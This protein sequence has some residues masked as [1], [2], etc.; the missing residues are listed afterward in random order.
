MLEL[1]PHLRK[2]ASSLKHGLPEDTVPQSKRLRSDRLLDSEQL[3]AQ[4][5]KNL[6]STQI[7]DQS[8]PSESTATCS[9]CV[10]QYPDEKRPPL[11]SFDSGV[12]IAREELISTSPSPAFGTGTSSKVNS[13]LS[14]TVGDTEASPQ[15]KATDECCDDIVSWTL[16]SDYDENKPVSTHIQQI[17]SLENELNRRCFADSAGC[18]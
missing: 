18:I 13:P 3:P 6:Q 16:Q 17:C 10:E 14:R 2:N 11:V 7:Y 1:A 9:D 5:Y 15:P 4:G 12:D 8:S